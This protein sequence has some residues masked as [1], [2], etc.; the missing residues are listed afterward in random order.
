MS[1][2][3][4]SLW[5]EKSKSFFYSAPTWEADL[6]EVAKGVLLLCQPSLGS[7]LEADHKYHLE[8]MVQWIFLNKGNCHEITVFL[9]AI[10]KIIRDQ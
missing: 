2:T 3:K 4:V 1:L 5:T 6:E 8:E 7:F 9:I 10:S